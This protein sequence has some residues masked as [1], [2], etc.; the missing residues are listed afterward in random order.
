MGI[1]VLTPDPD[2]FKEWLG[3]ELSDLH[4]SLT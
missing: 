1:S 3:T 4:N 2:T